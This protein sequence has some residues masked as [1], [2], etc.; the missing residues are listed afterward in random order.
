MQSALSGEKRLRKVF[1]ICSAP[2]IL[3]ATSLPT[4]KNTPCAQRRPCV[5]I[6]GTP[7]W[8][9]P[10]EKYF[11]ATALS[12]RNSK[13]SFAAHQ[14]W[15]HASGRDPTFKSAK[16]T[17]AHTKRKR[18]HTNGVAKKKATPTGQKTN[19]PT[20]TGPKPEALK[21]PF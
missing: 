11:P 1:N 9:D 17:G 16:K 14:K 20:K 12:P 19:R 8:Q 4:V 2:S 15:G 3:P 13:R 7:F 6:N 21:P 5:T 10:M 18:T